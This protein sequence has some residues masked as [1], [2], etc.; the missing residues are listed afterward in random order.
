MCFSKRTSFINFLVL[1]FYSFELYKNRNTDKNLWKLYIP[2]F[3][4]SLKDL[5]QYFLYKEKN[6]YIYGVLS[7]VHICFQPLFVNMLISYFSS[8]LTQYWNLIYFVSFI[9]GLYQLTTLDAFDIFNEGNFCKDPKSDFC[10]E[11]NGAYQGKY[12]IGYKFRTKYKHSK[13]F[14]LLMIIPGLFTSSWFHS[15]LWFFFVLLIRIIFN[16]VRDGEAGA[17]WCFLSIIP[18]IPVVYYRSSLQNMLN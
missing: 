5:L 9:Y 10:S 17:I 13:L 15:L 7:W 2:L 12:H 8:S 3:Y 11:T 1:S 18:A 14:L 6:K 16:G 4:L